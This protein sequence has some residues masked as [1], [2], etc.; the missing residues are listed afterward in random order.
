MSRIS[1]ASSNRRA[2]NELLKACR[3]GSVDVV[4]VWKFDRFARSLK[5]LMSG[6][7]TCR[8]LEIDFVSVMESIDTSL[9]SGELVFQMIG[10]V[11]QFDGSLIAE[12]V[13]S[14]L[15][16]CSGERESAWASI[17]A[18]TLACGKPSA[19]TGT[20]TAQHSVS[21]PRP[22]IR[23]VSVDRPPA[24]FKSFL[25]I[26]SVR[27][28][29]QSPAKYP[30]AKRLSRRAKNSQLVKSRYF[31]KMRIGPRGPD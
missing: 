26:A 12:R 18:Q 27:A 28:A 15:S 30:C 4:L 24:V 23:R 11:A 22:E 5:Q 19:Q 31:A 16:E 6:L 7:E 14:G 10:A 3:R 29:E 20:S 25:R 8:A 13:K 17:T 1:G 9:P 2:L 21:G